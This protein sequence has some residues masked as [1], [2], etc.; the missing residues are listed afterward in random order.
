M[1]P[2]L[3]KEQGGEWQQ[4]FF[5]YANGGKNLDTGE[6]FLFNGP[7][8]HVENWLYKKGLSTTER[9]ALVYLMEENMAKIDLRSLRPVV[10]EET[11]RDMRSI[12]F[13][14]DKDF[15]RLNDGRLEF[16]MISNLRLHQ[17]NTLSIIA[18]KLGMDGLNT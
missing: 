3:T 2:V 11:H 18:A 4:D 10:V 7:F 6:Q 16:N 8:G 14:L 9:N 1:N 15:Y 5:G 13:V 17:L 12:E